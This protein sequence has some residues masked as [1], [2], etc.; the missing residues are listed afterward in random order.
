MLY[1]L[2]ATQ[3]LASNPAALLVDLIG[4]YKGSNAALEYA[5][6]GVR[7]CLSSHR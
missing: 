7:A 4:E 2:D 5:L 1:P 3:R 6:Q